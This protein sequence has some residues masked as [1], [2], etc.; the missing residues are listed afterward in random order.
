MHELK[1]KVGDDVR[2]VKNTHGTH[3]IPIGEVRTVI[4]VERESR[5][6]SAPANYQE[7]CLFPGGNTWVDERDIKTT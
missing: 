5:E 7:Y 6:G 4:E 1:F 2:V 3:D